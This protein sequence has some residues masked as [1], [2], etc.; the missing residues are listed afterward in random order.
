MFILVLNCGSAT[1]K[2]KL[3]DVG[4]NDVSELASGCVEADGDYGAAVGRIIETLPEKPEAVAHRVV[5]GGDLY[6]RPVI[7]DEQVLEQLQAMSVLAPLHNPPALAGIRAAEVLSTPQV[8]VFDT[9]FHQTMPA[10]A[11]SYALPEKTTTDQRIRRYGFHGISHSYV[12]Q[13][14]S[15]LTGSVKPTIV[16]LHLGNGASACAVK[17]GCCVD[18]SMGVSPLEGLVMGS[19]GG[20]LDPAIVIQLQ[21]QGLSLDEVERL[22]W[23]QSGLIGLAGTNDMRELLEREDEQARLAVEVFCYRILK[24]IGAYLAVLGDAEAV[25]FTGGIGENSPAIRSRIICSLDNFGMELDPGGN[26][27]NSR[28]ITTDASTLHAWVIPTNEELLIARQAAK[29]LV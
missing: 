3:L 11:Y 2:Y 12:T 8:A 6:S 5:H 26:A 21:R 9:A 10:K 7:I 29:L 1:V 13:R 20:D 28:R 24:Y 16:T 27:K 4:G 18:T 23:H 22:L 25:V 17:D 19:R 15:E 14:Y